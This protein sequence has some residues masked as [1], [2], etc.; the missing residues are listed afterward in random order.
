MVLV[1]GLVVASSA[2]AGDVDMVFL[3][4]AVSTGAGANVASVNSS[5]LAALPMQKNKMRIPFLIFFCEPWLDFILFFFFGPWFVLV[6]FAWMGAHR[7]TTSLLVLALV[8]TTG[9]FIW[10]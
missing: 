5:H 4:S 1:L 9:W 8:P 10:R 2:K 3:K 6:Q 7:F